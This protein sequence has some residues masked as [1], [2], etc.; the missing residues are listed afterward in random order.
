MHIGPIAALIGQKFLNSSLYRGMCGGQ[1]GG[2]RTTV[3][4]SEGS[5]LPV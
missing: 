4:I 3:G 2:E 1:K 5:K